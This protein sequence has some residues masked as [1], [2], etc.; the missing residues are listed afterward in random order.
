ML[1]TRTLVTPLGRERYFFGLRPF[2]DNHKL[3]KE[4]YAYIPQSTVGDNTGL[5]INYAEPTYPNHIVLE[6]HDAITLEVPDNPLEIIRAAGVLRDAFKRILRF[7]KGL[8][9]EIPI[10]TEIGYNLQDTKKICLE[11][12][13]V[14]GLTSMLD[15]LRSSQTVLA[16]I[17]GGAPL[18][19][20]QQA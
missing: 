14:A 12:L 4:G 15:G 5:A 3:F 10:E 8:E 1:E 7:P 6:T 2:S 9:I 16:N 19:S 13:D 11:N 17:T 18:Q 20:L